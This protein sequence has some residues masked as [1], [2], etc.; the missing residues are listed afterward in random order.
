M[1]KNKS[2]DAGSNTDSN[3]DE[4]TGEVL[5]SGREKAEAFARSMG[6]AVDNKDRDEDD[7]TS[8]T[9][10]G[11]LVYIQPEAGHVLRGILLGRFKRPGKSLGN[12]Y[13]YRIE[14][15]K[16]CKAFTGKKDGQEE[17]TAKVG[18]VVNLDDRMGV[19]ILKDVASKV[20]AGGRYEVI[21]KC[22]QKMKVPNGTFWPYQV[23]A[24]SLEN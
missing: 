12:G 6:F 14:L 17:I 22:G 8:L 9:Q 2:V 7:F 15:T 16:E 11:E 21:V 4:D 3:I 24:R 18:Q 13:Y 10:E 20:E 19:S 23:L 5:M 1:A